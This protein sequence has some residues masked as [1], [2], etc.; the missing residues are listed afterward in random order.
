MSKF[1]SLL[2][3]RATLLI[4]IALV[5]IAYQFALLPV[6]AASEQES[7]AARFSFTRMDMPELPDSEY[8]VVLDVHPSVEHVSTWISAL[9][10]SVAF[11]DID[12][13]GLSNDTCF[14]ESRSGQVMVAPI[15]GTTARYDAFPVNATPLPFDETMVA[16]GCLVGD[17]N[18]DGR[19]DLFVFYFGRA[20]ILFLQQQAISLNEASFLPQETRHRIQRLVRRDGNPN[21]PRWL[22]AT[23]T[24]SWVRSSVKI[25]ICS[26]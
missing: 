7:V 25:R 16:I 3:R 18:E 24:S 5:I 14:I 6:L 17:F 20:P 10:A 15:P 2:R 9:G 13:D 19:S 22:T 26:M 21:R 12:G 11:N 8:D 23:T 1:G 4:S